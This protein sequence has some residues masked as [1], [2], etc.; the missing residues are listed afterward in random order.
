M[1]KLFFKTWNIALRRNW[2]HITISCDVH[3]V[4]LEANYKAGDIPK[5]FLGSAKLCYS[6]YPRGKM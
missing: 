5:T 3:D 1:K 4:I 6:A 2:D